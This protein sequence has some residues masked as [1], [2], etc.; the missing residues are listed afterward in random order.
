VT[1]AGGI[2]SNIKMNN[3]LRPDENGQSESVTANSHGRAPHRGLDAAGRW[4]AFGTLS[5]AQLMD[6]LAGT[7][8][9]HVCRAQ[10]GIRVVSELCHIPPETLGQHCHL[11]AYVDAHRCS[12]NR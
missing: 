1:K 2:E 3:S 5:L 10:V 6:V 8:F 4:L 12:G 7:V 11:R 9:V